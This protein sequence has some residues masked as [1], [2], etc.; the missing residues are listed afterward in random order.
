MAQTAGAHSS[1]DEPIATGGNREDLSDILFDVSP[2]ETPFITA[3]KKGKST[4]TSHDWLT[5][6]LSAPADNAN[7][8][9]DDANPEDA[10]S[11]L[12]LS[13]FTQILKKH[14][15]V[16]GT[17]ERVLKGGGIKS[18]MAY[19][20]A[21]RMKEMKRDFER[22]CVG[23]SNAKVAGDDSTAREMGSFDSYLVNGYN[24]TG[25]APTGNGVDAPGAGTGRDMTEDLFKD[26]LAA[27]WEQSGGNEN[28][29]ALC[30][31]H[32]R[33]VISGFNAS[34]TRYVTTDDKK[35]VASIDVYDGDFHTVTVTPDRY[36]KAT[37]CFIIDPEYVKIADLRPASTKDLAVNGDS[38]RKE[39]VWETTLEVCDPDAHMNIADLNTVAPAP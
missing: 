21:R 4:A 34:S 24:G 15:V 25:T 11:R 7:I 9:G 3:A 31:A 14:A 5:D 28:V 39:I 29:M 10:A 16:T 36:S 35:L 37:S 6:K 22:A 33:G 27:L 12:R 23:V 1:Y 17:Q 2:T 38:M 8:E 18:E 13:N 19:Q 26:A 20:V 30:G 32:V